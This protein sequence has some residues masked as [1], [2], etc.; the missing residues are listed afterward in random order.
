[1][2]DFTTLSDLAGVWQL[3]VDGK[4]IKSGNIAG[5]DELLPEE[6]LTV[7]LELPRN[8]PGKRA[9]V[10]FAFTSKRANAWSEAGTL[11]AHDQIE[12]TERLAL[13]SVE[14]AVDSTVPVLEKTKKT[15]DSLLTFS[16][17]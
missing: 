11:F 7:A 15:T 9:F 13:A 12:V 4:I 10:N 3:Q 1:M 14:N 5:L 8:L 2:R 17:Y 16:S 6:T